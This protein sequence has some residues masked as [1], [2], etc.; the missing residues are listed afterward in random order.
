MKLATI[1]NR[2]LKLETRV[3]TVDEAALMDCAMRR[4]YSRTHG[5]TAPAHVMDREADSLARMESLPA[6]TGPLLTAAWEIL[7]NPGPLYTET[8]C[9]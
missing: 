3:S 1:E 4:T 5:E 7:R 2:I 9:E 8:P 6:G